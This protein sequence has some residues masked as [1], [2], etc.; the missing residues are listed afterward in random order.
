MLRN[1]LKR[2]PI[3]IRDDRGNPVPLIAPPRIAKKDR[4]GWWNPKYTG[5]HAGYAVDW[6]V[7]MR[8]AQM[9]GVFCGLAMMVSRP[10]S[11]YWLR[12]TVFPGKTY[13]VMLLTGMLCWPFFPLVTRLIR[14]SR[15]RELRA[16]YLTARHCP[17]CDYALAKI[18]RP[19]G[20]TS[21]CPECGAAWKLDPAGRLEPQAINT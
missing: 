1:L 4:T 2:W 5:G 7:Q 14:N 18:P 12:N 17:S 19:D 9:Y 21:V 20:E 10:L 6:Q 13:L 3:T 11:E 16:A 15:R 8:T